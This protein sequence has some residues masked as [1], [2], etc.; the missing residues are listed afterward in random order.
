M[1]YVSEG[2]MRKAINILQ[3]SAMHSNHI[4]AKLVHKISS[5]ATPKEVKLMTELALEGKFQEA[6]E[7]LDKLIISY[8]LSG[9]DILLQ[10]YREI[11]K[12]EIPE[13]QK[14]KLIGMVGEYNFRL[15]QG[16]NERIQIEA[17]LAQF[18]GTKE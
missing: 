15:V 7:N 4:T 14:I 16:A 9:E 11:P 8:G 13:K 6:R 5:R 17:L 12:L 2:D 3:G 1:F 18:A 10:V